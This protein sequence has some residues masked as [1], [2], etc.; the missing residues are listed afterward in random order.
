MSSLKLTLQHI[1][2]HCQ[3]DVRLEKSHVKVLHFRI[4]PNQR[5]SYTIKGCTELTKARYLII[6]SA[7]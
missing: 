6:P 7:N 5:H 3:V 4:S 1:G 2:Y